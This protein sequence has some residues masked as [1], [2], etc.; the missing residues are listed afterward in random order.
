TADGRYLGITTVTA[1][2]WRALLGVM[3]RDDLVDD[4]ELTTM[5]GRFMRAAEVNTLLH[6]WTGAH[7]ADEI[8][9][10]CS[11]ARVP[12]ALVGNGELLPEFEQLR[13]R[14]VFVS[15]PGA[16][17]VR[18]RAPF[19]FHAIADRPLQPAPLLAGA[20]APLWPP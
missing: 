12:V 20:D 8:E 11:A 13:S 3:G 17:F 19:R 9:A 2:Q 7:T 1:A 18:P 5:I 4:E 14:D 16:G 6:D 15:Q 10:A